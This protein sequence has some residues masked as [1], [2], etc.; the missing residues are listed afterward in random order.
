MEVLMVS[1]RRPTDRARALVAG[2]YDLH[3]HVGPDIPTRQTDDVSLARRCAETGQAGFALKSHYTSTAERARVVSGIVPGVRI[4]G[5]VTLN[6]GVGGMNAIAVELAAREGARIV[7]MPTFD[8][9]A[10]TAGRHD[11]EQGVTPPAWAALQREL[12]ELGLPVDPVEVTDDEG[13]LLA[14]TREVLRT[15]ARND[16]VLATGHLARDDTLA[17]IEGAFEEGVEHVVI[18]HPEFPC[19]DFSI[20]DQVAFAERGCLLE[21]CLSTPLS[22]KTTFEHV[23]EGVR[24]VGIEKNFFSSDFGN[25]HYPPVEDGLS[26]WADYL[27][28]G[29]FDEDEVREMIVAASKRVAG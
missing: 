10:E 15:I 13:R 9:P 12:R 14:T 22:G 8:S 28:E 20:E 7:W 17:L 26:L 27:L 18:T 2:G 16:L 1:E 3:V 19:Q 4:I 5:T 21:R 11:P 29:G 23:F 24:A 6:R 25:P